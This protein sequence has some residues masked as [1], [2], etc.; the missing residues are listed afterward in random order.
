MRIVTLVIALLFTAKVAAETVYVTSLVWPPYSDSQMKELGAS[1]AVAKAAFSAMGH[2][3]V[4]EFYPW[5]RAVNLA[6]KEDSKYIG[7][8]PE[9]FFESDKFVFSNPMGK[10]PLGLVESVSSPISWSSYDDL[11]AYTIGVVQDYVN[12]EELDAKIASGEINAQ[13][14]T[15]DDKNLLKVAA[16]RINAAVIDANVFRYMVE[17]DKALAKVA[18]KLQMNPKLLVEKDLHIA[19]KNS[20]EGKRWQAIFNEG[21]EK[22]DVDAVM[23]D[24]LK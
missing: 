7:Y 13:T 1:I 15:S 5:S 8:L 6:E 12:T 9:Y 18:D 20:A 3:L 23:A 11:N 16:G 4:V 14:V 17:N 24:Y 21:L 2:E 10:G 22:I 19:F